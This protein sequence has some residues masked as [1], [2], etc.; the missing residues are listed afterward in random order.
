VALLDDSGLDAM[1]A[2]E[3]HHARRRD[4]L[5][6]AT[7][8]VAGVGLLAAAYARRHRVVTRRAAQQLPARG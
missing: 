1:L 3:H 5:R 7:G 2:H 4:P 8:R 6:L